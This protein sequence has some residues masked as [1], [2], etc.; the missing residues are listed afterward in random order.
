MSIAT[1]QRMV[2]D[3]RSPWSKE[4]AASSM[5]IPV[6]L[7]GNENMGD[8][9]QKF[10][11]WLAQVSVSLAALRDDTIR[12]RE[13]RCNYARWRVNMRLQQGAP[14]TKDQAMHGRCHSRSRSQAPAWKS[15]YESEC[16]TDQYLPGRSRSLVRNPAPPINE[17]AQK[18]AVSSLKRYKP[19]QR[20]D[21]RRRSFRNDEGKRDDSCCSKCNRNWT[22]LNSRVQHLEALVSR[23]DPTPANTINGS[24][25]S[26]YEIYGDAASSQSGASPTMID[27]TDDVEG[28]ADSDQA[29][30]NENDPLLTRPTD[31][32]TTETQSRSVEITP[33]D[34]ELNHEGPS[35]DEGQGDPSTQDADGLEL[36]F[37]ESRKKKLTLL[38]AWRSSLARPA[39]WNRRVRFKTSETHSRKIKKSGTA[40]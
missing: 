13:Y 20:Y 24:S 28:D 37:C 16:V 38:Q 35:T 19:S 25:A 1:Y 21:T 2:N 6:P 10:E 15:R 3:P 33:T 18:D 40:P 4:S 39:L 23:L 22:D 31:A 11:F 7:E 26:P 32:P 14:A 9:Q 27:L 29:H 34:S 8:Y 30:A 5:P 36:K 12:E 17:G